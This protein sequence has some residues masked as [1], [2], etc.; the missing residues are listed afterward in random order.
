LQADERALSSVV[1]DQRIAQIF[2]AEE[3]VFGGE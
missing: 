2:A 1:S 3:I